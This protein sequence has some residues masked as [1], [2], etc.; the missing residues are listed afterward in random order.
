MKRV[1]SANKR[2]VPTVAEVEDLLIKNDINFDEV[3]DLSEDD[4]VIYFVVTYG[5]WRDNERARDLINSKF[6]PNSID[7]AE[8]DPKDYGIAVDFDGSDSAVMRHVC[9]WSN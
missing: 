9:H 3:S 4:E 1:I 2:I 5:D 6:S 7:S 8:I